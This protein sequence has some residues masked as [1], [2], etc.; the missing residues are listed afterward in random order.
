[1]A[2]RERT[3]MLVPHP[4]RPGSMVAF[5]A[6]PAFLI[7]LTLISV[8]LRVIPWDTRGMPAVRGVTSCDVSEATP[9]SA[10]VRKGPCEPT[11]RVVEIARHAVGPGYGVEAT[12]QLVVEGDTCEVTLWRFP[13]RPGGY[14]VVK[15]GADGK[16]V[17]VRP[18]L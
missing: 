8:P 6:L 10:A 4:S 16:V 12:P 9:E 18:G 3:P 5:A 11:T 14:R 7:L 1:M 15:V 13:K 2:R 17:S